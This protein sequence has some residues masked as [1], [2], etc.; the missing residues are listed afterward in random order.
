MNTFRRPHVPISVVASLLFTVAAGR[1]G[2][3]PICHACFW[4]H[5]PEALKAELLATLSDR[6][7]PDPLVEARRRMIVAR[8]AQDEAA[9]CSAR[10]SLF[11]IAGPWALANEERALAIAETLAFTAKECGDDAKLRFETAAQIARQTGWTWKAEVYDSLAKGRFEPRFE[12]TRIRR[13]LEVPSRPRS[14]VLGTSQIVVASGTRVGAQVERTVR[15]WLSYQLGWDESARPVRK[16]ELLTWHEGARLR[17]LLDAV[18][19]EIVPLSGALAAR[20]NGVWYAAGEDG[21][22]R[23]EILDDKMQY[24]T[25]VASGDVALIVDT[26]GLSALVAQA[27]QRRSKLIVGCC[28]SQG[29]AE[30]AFDLARRN[31]DVW[32]PCDRFVGD[33]VGYDAPGVLIG[34]APVRPEGDRA[35]IGD[36][37]VRFWTNETIVVQDFEGNGGARYYDAPARYVRALQKLAK[38]KA[39]YVEVDGPG[40]SARVVGRAEKL[41]ASAI[42]VRVET[43]E[44]A[45][46]VRAWLAAAP[47]R[48]AILV[49]TAAYAAG[50]ALFT[51]FPKQTTFADPRPKFE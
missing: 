16:E 36:R 40:Q 13:K 34:S 10:K 44:D 39:D 41:G 12:T 6:H 20:K 50:H 47:R 46:P 51:E 48:R 37:P 33:L 42:A 27:A 32:F 28:D 29:K 18:P 30:A 45:A 38:V 26:H 22:F 9:F 35:I 21:A 14:F 5:Q 1:N 3:D 17:D 7:Y 24:P 23:Y 19:A 15:D 25:T 31:V 2:A 11:P 49:H 4:E 8:T 43:A